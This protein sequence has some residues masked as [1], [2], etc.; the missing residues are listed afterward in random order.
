MR[1]HV[2]DWAA[3]GASAV[4]KV[5]RS[6]RG[7]K[8]FAQCSPIIQRAFLGWRPRSQPATMSRMNPIQR[9]AS[10]LPL[11][12]SSVLLAQCGGES[13]PQRS[14]APATLPFIHD[15]YTAALTQARN[16]KVPLFID[17]WAPW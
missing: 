14:A 4:V 3:T 15:D 5:H 13:T 17:T 11:A 9:L 8:S 10:L 12:I 6:L 16:Q 7:P 2:D 1:P